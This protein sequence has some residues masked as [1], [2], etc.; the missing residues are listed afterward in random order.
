M[1]T[2]DVML[3]ELILVTAMG[4]SNVATF[5]DEYEGLTYADEWRLQNVK[6]GCVPVQDPEMQ[7]G[8]ILDMMNRLTAED[9]E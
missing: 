1:L 6:A 3:Y 2:G 5:S 8:K 9:Y 4:V 7:L